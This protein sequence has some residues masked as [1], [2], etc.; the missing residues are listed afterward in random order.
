MFTDTWGSLARGEVVR[1]RCDNPRCI[2]PVHLERGT[3]LDNVRDRVE[4]DRSAKGER[5]GKSRLTDAQRAEIKGSTETP[6]VLARRYGVSP[7]TIR[8]TRS[9]PGQ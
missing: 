7:A 1:H 2:N 3:Q 5:N 6:A 8:Y 9:R 4:R